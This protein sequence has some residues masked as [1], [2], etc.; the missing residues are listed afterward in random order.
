M[1]QEIV[2][3]ALEIVAN[4][5]GVVTVRDEAD[6][7]GQERILD[8]HLLEPDRSGLAG[9]LGEPAIWSTSSR[10]VVRRIVNANL[11]PSGRPW[12]IETSGKRIRVAENEPPKMM[13]RA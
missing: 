5:A 11:A 12:K 10:W 3:V 7:L 13:M 2:A 1:G 9:D 8:L 6:A 4:E